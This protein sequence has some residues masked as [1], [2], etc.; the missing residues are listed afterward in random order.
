[1]R[2]VAALILALAL[3]AMAADR[4]E[5]ITP[6]TARAWSFLSDQVMG[7]VSQGAAAY[8]EEGGTGYLR[9]I[10][11]VSTANR[12]GFVQIR[13]AFSVPEGA[14]GLILKVRGNGE[15]YF[16]HLRTRGLRMPWQFYQAS[17]ETG[18]DWREVR[19]PFAAFAPRGGFQR[20]TLRPE[21][22]ES[23]GLAAY[24]RDHRADVSVAAVGVY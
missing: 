15:R 10:G 6:D 21:T 22:V 7:G 4:M 23:L 8:A 16:A 17:F 13:R 2:L 19:L 5:T 20:A 12:G 1:M 11:D 18:P 3:P 24:G 14:T 9:L